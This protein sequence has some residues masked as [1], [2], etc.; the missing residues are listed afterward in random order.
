[1]CKNMMDFWKKYN[2][3]IPDHF[4]NNAPLWSYF[5]VWSLLDLAFLKND[6]ACQLFVFGTILYFPCKC[7]PW[8]LR[9]NASQSSLH[10]KWYLSPMHLEYQTWSLLKRQAMITLDGSLHCGGTIITE[11]SVMTAASCCKTQ[12]IFLT[13]VA[14]EHNVSDEDGLEQRVPVREL[15]AH[16][17][18]NTTVEWSPYDACIMKLGKPLKLVYYVQTAKLPTPGQ[19][20]ST[21]T[22]PTVLGWGSH[23]VLQELDL[24]LANITECQDWYTPLE[25]SEK[26]IICATGTE[27]DDCLDPS[28]D[29]G[30]PLICTEGWVCGIASTEIGCGVK[31]IMFTRVSM[32]LDFIYHHSLPPTTLRPKPIVIVP[33]H[34]YGSPQSDWSVLG[35]FTFVIFT[36]LNF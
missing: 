1:M 3:H 27:V 13:V 20:F 15:F 22:T 10:G 24:P 35:L 16:P 6:S 21:E 25:V 23:D 17:K 9:F 33:Y 4:S 5:C 34:S 36:I 12:P 30:G 8:G 11:D 18:Y 14:G 31:P 28:G 7:N 2:N 32:I 19:I 26:T 29:N